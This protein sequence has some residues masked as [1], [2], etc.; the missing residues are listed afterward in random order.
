MRVRID[1]C[2]F[3]LRVFAKRMERIGA[4]YEPAVGH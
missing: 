1:I 2:D 3:H 4:R